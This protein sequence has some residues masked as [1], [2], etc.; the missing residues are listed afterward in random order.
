MKTKKGS[1]PA[2]QR[3]D[4]EGLKENSDRSDNQLKDAL[5][6]RIFAPPE[7]KDLIARKLEKMQASS[8]I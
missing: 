6:K 7:D 2:P 1:I 5:D 8:E 4:V 3:S